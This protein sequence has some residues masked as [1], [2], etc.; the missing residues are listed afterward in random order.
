LCECS[1]FLFLQEH[2][3][4]PDELDVLNNIHSDFYGVG[5][6][7]VELDNDIVLGRPFGG[8]CILYRKCLA[9]HVSTLVTHDPRITAGTFDSNLGLVLMIC[10]YMPTDYGSY[11]SY[12]QYADTCAKVVAMYEDSD[13]VDVVLCGDFNCQPG[14]RFYSLY[15]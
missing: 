9:Q 15:T 8:T 1:D 5:Y 4:L 12:E 10:V 6:S 11:D 14:S 13:A 3:L 7:A 2:W